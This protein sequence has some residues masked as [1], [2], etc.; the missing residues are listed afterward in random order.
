MKEVVGYYVLNDG[1]YSFMT[2]VMIESDDGRIIDLFISRIL[3]IHRYSET[4]FLL[5]VIREIID[6]I[7]NPYLR[8]RNGHKL[9]RLIIT[10]LYLC[11][12]SEPLS[13]LAVSRDNNAY[14][15]R[16]RYNALHIGRSLVSVLDILINSGYVAQ[17]VG[18]FDNTT[19]RGYTSRIWATQ[20]LVKLFQN[21]DHNPFTCTYHP[22][23][24]PIILR[25][26]EGNDI[27]YDDTSETI[28]MRNIVKRYN[29]FLSNIFIDI[30]TLEETG[31]MIETVRG[32]RWLH[33]NQT[34]NFTRRIF[35]NNSFQ[36]GGRFYGGW[37]QHC[38]KEYRSQIFIDDKATSEIDYSNNHIVLLYAEKGMKWGGGDAYDIE[39]PT[40]L[41]HIDD[42]RALVKSLLLIAINAENESK[43]YEAFRSE[44]KTGTPEKRLTN[45]QLSLVLDLLR[46]KHSPIADKLASGAGIELQFTDSQITEKI[47][48]RCMDHEVP[49]LIVHDSFI[50]PDGEEHFIR[51]TMTRAFKEVTGMEFVPM[52]EKTHHPEAYLPESSDDYGVDIKAVEAAMEYRHNPVRSERYLQLKQAFDRQRDHLVA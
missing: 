3:D 34:P 46:K 41:S 29:D 22:D 39:C 13:C 11:W 31:I 21:L 45:T 1:D 4:S 23:R 14:R 36:N 33:I 32:P 19:G 20:K 43:T 37:W 5:T 28:R 18:F 26:P 27:E 38:P 17:K 48:T 15:S 50:V 16:S 49:V 51:D 35:N 52:E 47:I 30:P 2:T 7:D 12:V 24:E 10:D 8:S 40:D 9:T 42:F 25:D 6:T 44:A